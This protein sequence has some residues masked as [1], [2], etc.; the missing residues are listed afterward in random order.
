MAIIIIFNSIC[1]N[2]SRASCNN[3]RSSKISATHLCFADVQYALRGIFWDFRQLKKIN[4]QRNKCQIENF[5]HSVLCHPFIHKIVKGYQNHLHFFVYALPF[6]W[7]E[8]LLWMIPEILA[9]L[10]ISRMRFT[11]CPQSATF[12]P[13][14]LISFSMFY[15]LL[16]SFPDFLN[17]AINSKTNCF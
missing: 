5:A 3:F 11:T 7:V 17:L 4:H 8:I 9:K 16:T 12:E 2:K 10:R 14:F 6:R 15:I 1:F 13:S